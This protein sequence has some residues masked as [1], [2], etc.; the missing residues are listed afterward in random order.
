MRDI[1]AGATC[2]TEMVSHTYYFNPLRN[3]SYLFSLHQQM[4]VECF[5]HLPTW[6]QRSPLIVPGLESLG[7]VAPNINLPVFTTFRPSQT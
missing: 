1:T 7:S 2:E 4:Y 5:A 6:M 3:S